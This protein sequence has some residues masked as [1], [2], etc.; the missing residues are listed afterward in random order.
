MHI[1]FWKSSDGSIQV[2][3]LGHYVGNV[4]TWMCD[5]TQLINAAGVMSLCPYQ[6]MF[7]QLRL[8]NRSENTAVFF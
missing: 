3:K 5:V 7:C 4:V 6:I 2:C 8:M 1:W